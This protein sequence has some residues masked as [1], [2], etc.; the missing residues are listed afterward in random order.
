[1]L[2]IGRRSLRPGRH[3]ITITP[4]D[5]DGRPGAPLRLTLKL[6]R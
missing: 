6:K 2:R 4:I 3:R 1:V 5:A